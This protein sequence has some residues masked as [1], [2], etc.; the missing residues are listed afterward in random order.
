[1]MGLATAHLAEVLDDDRVR[2]TTARRPQLQALEAARTRHE[3]QRRLV[4]LSLLL[5]DRGRRR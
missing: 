2:G 3:R 1:M 4:G 5:V